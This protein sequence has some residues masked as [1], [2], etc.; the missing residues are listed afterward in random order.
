MFRILVLVKLFFVL[1]DQVPIYGIFWCKGALI[2]TG[3]PGA[4]L[5]CVF[6]GVWTLEFPCLICAPTIL[7]G[8]W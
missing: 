5:E 2:E 6:G 7:W 4:T 3:L 1:R 8:R